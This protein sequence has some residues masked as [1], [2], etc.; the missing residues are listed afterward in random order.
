MSAAE[1]ERQ[2]LDLI[3]P[4]LTAEGYTVLRN[5]S[6]TILPPFMKGYV[7]DAIALG[8]PRNLAIEI[9]N[10]ARDT[11]RKREGLTERFDG[12]SDWEL[13]VFYL[14]SFT[15]DVSL[16]KPTVDV[17]ETVIGKV[18]TLVDAGQTEAALLLVWAGFEAFG[19]ML[20]PNALS[21]PQPTSQLLER[22]AGDGIV[23]P[24]EAEWLRDLAAVRN[25]VAHGDLTRTV[26][27]ERILELLSILRR[28]LHEEACPS[29]APAEP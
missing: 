21:R 13:R 29:E 16:K 8:K 20:L 3:A 5:P 15:D 1:R 2:V 9:V 26:D 4:R 17:I 22:L 27:P 14:A 11:T 6:R 19:R 7:P 10:D 25:A 28:A 12:V 24:D 23:T 18:G